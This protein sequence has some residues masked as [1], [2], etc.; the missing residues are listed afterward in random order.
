MVD[1]QLPIARADLHV[2]SCHSRQSGNFRF[3]KSRDCYA[4][5]ADVYRI[6]KARGMDFVTL[7][8]H[9]SIDGCL[10]FFDEHHGVRD[11]FVS[12]EVSCRFPGT[13]LEVHLGVYGL[14]ERLHRELQR[15][16]GNVF[17]AADLLRRTET[18]FSLNHLL[19]FYRGQVPFDEYLRL[20]D[21]VPALEARNGTMLREHN[22]LVSR[23]ALWPARGRGTLGRVGGSDAHTLRRVGRTWTSA[24]GAT[25]EQF[26]AS[27]AR[28][29]GDVGGLH[30]TAGV[31]AAD[32]YGVILRYVGSLLGL[33]PRD[34]RPLRRIACLLFSAVSVPAQS[35]PVVIATRGKIAERREVRRATLALERVLGRAVAD[36]GAE[37]C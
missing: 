35:L 7:T 4:R 10:E 19:H 2:H 20:L 16:R 25:V 28:G 12:E 8:D 5:P 32:A 29:N 24:P 23:L 26:V 37:K 18:F 6:A 31:V 11:F 9:D 36:A 13:D 27:L 30:G 14:T 1:S 17:D 21:A 22:E 34:H 33:G 3:L 15:V